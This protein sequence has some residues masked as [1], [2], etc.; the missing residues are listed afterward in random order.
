[1]TTHEGP[2]GYRELLVKQAI[3]DAHS[4]YCRA[5][6]RRDEAAAAAIWHADGTADYGDIFKGSGAGFAA[7]VTETHL[8]FDRHSHQISNVLVEVAPSGEEAVSE[9]YITVALWTVPDVMGSVTQVTSRGRYLDHWT[10]RDEGWAIIERHFVEDFTTSQQLSADEVF[11][12]SRI[13]RRDPDDPSYAFFSR[14]R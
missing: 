4:R 2:P 8:N 12:A 7:W 9:A 14:V 3:R 5:M 11:P 10:R 1:M 6:D 13:S